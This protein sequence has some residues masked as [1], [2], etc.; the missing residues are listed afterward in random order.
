MN[1]LL[2]SKSETCRELKSGRR[3]GG[4]R[5]ILDKL[6]EM[7]IIVMLL[8]SWIFFICY[9]DKFL[10]L[11]N[12][13]TLLGTNAYFAVTAIGEV[14]VMLTGGIDLSVAQIVAFS[15]VASAST[16][17]KMLDAG[18]ETSEV[19]FVGI[20][21]S[22][23]IGIV[24]GLINGTLIGFL[25]INGFIV[26]MST[27]LVARGL[28]LVSSNAGRSIG[29]I[30]EDI[31]K[32]STSYGIHIGESLTIPWII[33][34]AILLLGVFGFLLSQTDWGRQII[35]V[36]AKK[37]AAR[38][39]GINTKLV[40]ASTYYVAGLVSGIAGFMTMMCLGCGDPKL[41]DRLLM[42]IIGAVVLGGIDMNGGE[43]TMTKGVLGML[44]FA[45]II[46]GMTFMNLTL[47]AQQIV[48]GITIIIGTMILALINRRKRI[49]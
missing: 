45:T 2:Q 8:A 47:S 5:I 22:V 14:Y 18:A 17:S 43:G 28:A 46:N 15:A 16:M 38:Y 44:M 1:K 25:N 26:T 3:F 19:V 42:P 48:Q 36:G 30:P 12:I 7:P 34:L 49:A 39:I 31:V 33:L 24:F 32:M 29:N 20:V 40:I 37:E 21:I 27:Q 6:V 9:S 13:L 10:T 11:S 4:V 41:G 35:L 23:A